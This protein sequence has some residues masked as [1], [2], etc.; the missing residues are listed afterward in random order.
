MSAATDGGVTTFERNILPHIARLSLA[1][2]DGGDRPL[3]ALLLAH[4]AGQKVPQS[5]L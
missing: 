2:L 5:Q 1:V 4:Q 3:T